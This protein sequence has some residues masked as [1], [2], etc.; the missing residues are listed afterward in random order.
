MS[1]AAVKRPATGRTTK[2]TSRDGLQERVIAAFSGPD[3]VQA[4]LDSLDAP[5]KQQLGDKT[6][7]V[8]MARIDAGLDEIERL[9]GRPNLRAA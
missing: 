3:V 5:A 7:E 9:Q 8:L 2:R 6:F 4:V 1:R